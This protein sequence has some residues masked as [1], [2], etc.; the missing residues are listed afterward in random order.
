MR[1]CWFCCCRW[2]WSRP[3]LPACHQIEVHEALTAQVRW[4]R[5]TDVRRSPRGVYQ[6]S[7]QRNGRSNRH[8]ENYLPAVAQPTA[9]TCGSFASRTCFRGCRSSAD[10][11]RHDPHL[12][13][14]CDRIRWPASPAGQR[15]ALCTGANAAGDSRCS[16]MCHNL[17][18]GDTADATQRPDG[19]RYRRADFL[20]GRDRRRSLGALDR[21]MRVTAAPSIRRPH[22]LGT[23]V[24][25]SVGGGGLLSP[26]RSLS[27]TQDRRPG[28]QRSWRSA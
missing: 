2:A 25:D 7:D 24:E 14:C 6:D 10:G 4:I 17:D 27:P 1:C 11:R 16:G 18:C 22:R 8:P 19:Q 13:V 23:E 28:V 20:K 5:G 12:S 9:A 3:A 15:C 26:P 21:P